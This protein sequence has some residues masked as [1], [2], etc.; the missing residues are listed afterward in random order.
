MGKEKEQGAGSRFTKKSLFQLE[1][2]PEIQTLGLVDYHSCLCSPFALVL[3]TL[4]WPLGV[5]SKINGVL[6]ALGCLHDALTAANTKQLNSADWVLRGN[7]KKVSVRR[8]DSQA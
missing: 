3:Q 6:V 5:W 4:W 2:R 7:C 8:S 1:T